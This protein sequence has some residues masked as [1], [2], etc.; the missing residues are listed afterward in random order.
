M[1]HKK[2]PSVKQVK[3]I[4]W[5]KLRTD[6]SN[7]QGSVIAIQMAL[8]SAKLGMGRPLNNLGSDVRYSA[9]INWNSKKRTYEGKRRGKCHR[10]NRNNINFEGKHV[11]NLKEAQTFKIIQT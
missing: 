9:W 5:K 10:R 8:K 11:L 1:H 6:V 3:E 2:P 4:Q 7:P